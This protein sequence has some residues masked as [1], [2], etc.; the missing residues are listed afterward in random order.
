MENSRFILSNLLGV[1]LIIFYILA[2]KKSS[3]I[4][5]KDYKTAFITI[6]IL[7][8]MMC[9]V[10]KAVQPGG[11]SSPFAIAGI[12]LGI[13]AFILILITIFGDVS[14]QEKVF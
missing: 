8:F 2:E 7:G 6:A 4:L 13:I 11:W 14:G 9:T 12:L 10:Y 1:A 5:V 3:F